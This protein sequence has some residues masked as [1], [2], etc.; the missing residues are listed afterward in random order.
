M[1]QQPQ[2]CSQPRQ[3]D[4]EDICDSENRQTKTATDPNDVIPDVPGKKIHGLDDVIGRSTPSDS[5]VGISDVDEDHERCC[6]PNLDDYILDTVRACQT[7]PDGNELEGLLT[8]KSRDTDPVSDRERTSSK[9]NCNAKKKCRTAKSQK[10][11]RKSKTGS[12]QTANDNDAK[13]KKQK[14]GQMT[15]WSHLK[16]SPTFRRELPLGQSTTNA[17]VQTDT[18]STFGPSESARSAGKANAN[19]HGVD[20]FVNVIALVQSLSADRMSWRTLLRLLDQNTTVK[21]DYFALYSWAMRKKLAFRTSASNTKRAV[22]LPKDNKPDKFLQVDGVS[23]GQQLISLPCGVIT[24]DSRSP[25]SQK[26]PWKREVRKT[27][28]EMA[29]LAGKEQCS[30][31]GKPGHPRTPRSSKSKSAHCHSDNVQKD[32]GIDL[33]LL[34]DT[35]SQKSASRFPQIHSPGKV[36]QLHYHRPRR[37]VSECPEKT[38]C[39]SNTESL[40]TVMNYSCSGVAGRRHRQN[41]YDIN[42]H[43]ARYVK[44]PDI[45]RDIHGDN[46]DLVS[47]AATDCVDLRAF[48]RKS[49]IAPS[50]PPGSPVS[51]VIRPTPCCSETDDTHLRKPS[52][53]VIQ[54]PIPS[55]VCE[56]TNIDHIDTKS[57]VVLGA[58]KSTRVL[59]VCLPQVEPDSSLSVSP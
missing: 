20:P 18:P 53:S 44:L 3:L 46:D 35:G 55:I 12:L 41:D 47:A 59:T 45:H 7:Q 28:G 11:R 13:S 29:L 38:N 10:T 37:T 33:R 24:P 54:S 8:C 30:T 19:A 17:S 14:R 26:R 16:N 15:P 23:T 21:G 31:A 52:G 2:V 39:L 58:K 22:D 5:G 27:P 50:P 48:I 25:R 57:G 49:S 51:M 40:L 43:R 56:D 9:A 4:P 1:N 32:F 6:T 42:T 36:L 34:D